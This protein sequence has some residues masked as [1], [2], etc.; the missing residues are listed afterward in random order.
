MVDAYRILPHAEKHA[1]AAASGKHWAK[2]RVHALET[3]DYRV[4]IFVFVTYLILDIFWALYMK[5]VADNRALYAANCNIGICFTTA[6]GVLSYTENWLYIFPLVAG[7]WVGTYFTVRRA[8]K[9]D[10]S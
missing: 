4:A 3:F 8:E 10:Q 7:A 2:P 6:L 9:N 5:A 1:S